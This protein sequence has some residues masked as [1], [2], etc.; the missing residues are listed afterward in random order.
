MKLLNKLKLFMKNDLIYL[1]HIVDAIEKVDGYLGI[2][3]FGDFEKNDLVINATIRQL[4]IIGE[5]AAR[6]SKEFKARNKNVPWMEI[7][8]MR[9]RLIHEYFGVDVKV[10]WETSKKDLPELKEELLK[11][12]E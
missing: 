1:K 7:I 2:I 9:N 12:L 4:E 10:V 8:G 3:K 11:I 6:I 5:A